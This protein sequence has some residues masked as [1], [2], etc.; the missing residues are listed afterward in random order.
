[1]SVSDSIFFRN[2][3]CEISPSENEDSNIL[4]IGYRNGYIDIIDSRISSILI[5]IEIK[6]F[7]N[8]IFSEIILKL[9]NRG[10]LCEL[11]PNING[12]TISTL[13]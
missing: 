11:L 2:P 9:N 8:I 4:M 12:V 3:G 6:L 5:I 1:M 7:I 13:N 10:P